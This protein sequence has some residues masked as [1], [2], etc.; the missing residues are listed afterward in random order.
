MVLFCAVE[1]SSAER[2]PLKVERLPFYRI[3][4][5]SYHGFLAINTRYVIV[6]V[7]FSGL[8]TGQFKPGVSDRVG[9]GRVSVIWP[10]SREI[11]RTY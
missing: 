3:T 8:C 6:S 11:F 1:L 4:L 10:V 5:L 9:T 2:I 7:F